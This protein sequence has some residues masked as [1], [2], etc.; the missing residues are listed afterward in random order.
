MITC[1]K[2]TASLAEI[3]AL[4]W[5]TM[6]CGKAVGLA[7]RPRTIASVMAPVPIKPIFWG[8]DMRGLHCS[9]W[10]ERDIGRVIFAR[11]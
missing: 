4:R 5:D 9:D 6:T 11:C 8:R 3:S 10:T 1:G 7:S 2:S